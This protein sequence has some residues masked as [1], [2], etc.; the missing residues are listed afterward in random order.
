MPYEAIEIIIISSIII[1]TKTKIPNCNH[2]HKH[3]QFFFFIFF[4]FYPN[5][6]L[7]LIMVNCHIIEGFFHSKKTKKNTFRLHTKRDNECECGSPK[8]HLPFFSIYFCHHDHSKLSLRL[9]S[10]V[11]P[12]G[13]CWC[14]VASIC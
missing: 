8:Y 10:I 5:I 1:L 11:Y 12:I 3:Y 2:N 13:L 14:L 9:L 4:V 7:M 6:V